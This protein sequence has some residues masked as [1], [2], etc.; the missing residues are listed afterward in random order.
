MLQ[1]AEGVRCQ[2]AVVLSTETCK[3]RFSVSWNWISILFR[4]WL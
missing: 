3:I 1:D 2:L 4:K